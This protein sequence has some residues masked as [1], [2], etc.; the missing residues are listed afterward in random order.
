MGK[1]NTVVVLSS[2]DEGDFSLSS[3]RS[4]TRSKLSSTVPRANPRRSK[5]P[6]LSGSRSGLSKDSCNWDEVILF[7]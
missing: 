5:K 1:R 4:R 6:R 2:E 7:L 3:S